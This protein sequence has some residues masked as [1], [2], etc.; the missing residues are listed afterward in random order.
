MVE[1][2]PKF[3]DK[4]LSENFSDENFKRSAIL[5]AEPWLEFGSEHVHHLSWTAFDPKPT[6]VKEKR[7]R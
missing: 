7:N 6:V 3:S 1:M 4:H 2:C 5:R